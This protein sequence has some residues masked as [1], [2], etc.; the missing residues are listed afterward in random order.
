MSAPPPEFRAVYDAHF[1]FVW[2]SLR[3]LGVREADAFD[4]SQKVFL[5]V[6]AKLSEFERRAQLSTWLFAIC[7]RVASDYRRS[8]AVRR[9]V[10]TDATHMDRYDSTSHDS[11][12]HAERQHRAETAE[13]LLDKLPESQ[14]VVFVMFEVEELSGETIGQQL[15]IS[16][17]TVRSRLRLAR[18]T[19]SREVKRLALTRGS[20][21]REA[22]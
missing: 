4:A 12:T 19:F 2:C 16:V 22:G 5:I 13:A 11:S 3:R 17:G 21:R 10:I 18:E 7:R 8:A 15:G 14:R 9:E 20:G 6:H 1:D